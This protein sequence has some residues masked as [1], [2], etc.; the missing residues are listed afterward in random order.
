MP[1]F[2]Q[3]EPGRAFL[4]V[5]KP[6]ML[7]PN[8]SETVVLVV[9]QDEGGPTGRHTQSPHAHELRELYPDRPG[10]AQR[11][12]LLFFGG[13]VQPDALLFAFRSPRKPSKGLHVIDNIYISGFSE[14]LAELLEHPEDATSSVFMPAIPGGPQAS[15]KRRLRRAA[16][17]CCLW[18]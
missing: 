3:Q 5:A 13:P 11:D 17:T 6:G 10:L 8:F 14:V 1:A 2:A 16:G 4:L 9:R 18:T 12:D 7:D 15:S